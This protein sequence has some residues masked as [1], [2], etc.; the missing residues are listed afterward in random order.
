[1]L[2]NVV[3]STFDRFELL[4][5]R[6]KSI[7]N[8]DYKDISIFVIVDGNEKMINELKD[9]PVEILFNPERMDY[10]I[11]INKAIKHIKDGA[12]LYASDDLIF[13]PNCISNAAKAMKE[14]FPDTDGLIALKQ[15][16]KEGGAAFGL[17]G[18]KFINRFS[19][20]EVFCPEFIHYGGDTELR[21]FAQSIGRFHQCRE[22]IIDHSR[23]CD[24]TFKLAR[25]VKTHDK[26]IYKRRRC[27]KFLWGESFERV[28]E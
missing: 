26:Q 27:K 24:N 22:A 25:K 19:N 5:K 9:E 28:R 15:V 20:G 7:V 8:S 11:S 4:R 17:L 1:M 2:I 3:I 12:V 18:R 21:D 16:Q 13:W 23:Q 10:I 6:I 14:H